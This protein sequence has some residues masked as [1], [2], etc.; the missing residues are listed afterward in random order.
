MLLLAALAQFLLLIV[1]PVSGAQCPPRDNLPSPT[2]EDKVAGSEVV[3]QGHASRGLYRVDETRDGVEVNVECVY[4]GGPVPRVIN[5][6]GVAGCGLNQLLD[7][8]TYL[9]Y[10]K[11]E[12]SR[13][14]P[15]FNADPDDRRYLDELEVVCGLHVQLPAGVPSS[16]KCRP[17]KF[18]TGDSSD[19]SVPMKTTG[20]P[21]AD[22][23]STASGMFQV[24]WI[25]WTLL[26]SMA[27]LGT[28]LGHR[29]LN[30]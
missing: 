22:G 19:C 26:A 28:A 20:R 7:K 13:H 30:S 24:F 23:S 29:L 14:V 18:Q 12:G 8:Q 21:S 16:S 1:P 15:S 2:L 25:Q 10:L 6:T 5:V 17:E 9:M 27:V 3:V 4:K 11:R